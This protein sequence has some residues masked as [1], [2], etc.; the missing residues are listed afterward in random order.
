MA[1]SAVRPT[2][3]ACRVCDDQGTGRSGPSTG[4]GDGS[5]ASRSSFRGEQARLRVAL[6]RY[7]AASFAC[8]H[9]RRM[10]AQ[11]SPMEPARGTAQPGSAL[12]ERRISLLRTCVGQVYELDLCEPQRRT[13]VDFR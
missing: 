11:I 2:A 9:E 3:I 12:R 6:R 8:I 1:A 4:L 10:V 7:G 13:L 5:L